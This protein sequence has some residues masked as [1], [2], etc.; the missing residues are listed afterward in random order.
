[1]R[2]KLA[3]A[4]VLCLA[5]VTPASA[6]G[7]PPTATSTSDTAV[8]YYQWTTT[9]FGATCVILTLAET[10]YQPVGGPSVDGQTLHVAVKTEACTPGSTTAPVTEGT[11]DLGSSEYRVNTLDS[12]YVRRWVEI[13]YPIGLGPL[14]IDVAWV[15][16][17]D[18]VSCPDSGPE[19]RWQARCAP[20]HM[21]GVVKNPGRVYEPIQ[22]E[23]LLREQLRIIHY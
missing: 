8:A 23:A 1:M 11:F 14:W 2:S 7:A 22:Q 6:A 10:T 12:A 21:T 3:F 13:Y 4:A 17:G 16:V 15:A 20:A 9:S 18:P 5:L 19:Y